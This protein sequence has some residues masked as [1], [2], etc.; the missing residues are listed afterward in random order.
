M[1]PPIGVVSGPLMP[2]RYFLKSTIVSSGS[3]LFVC[4]NAFSP[5]STSCHAIFFLPPYAFSTAA[6]KTRTLARQMSRPVPSPSMKGTIGLSGTWSLLP[7]PIVIGWPFGAADIGEP[8]RK[9]RRRTPYHGSPAAG[10][11]G[12]AKFFHLL[13]LGGAEGPCCRAPCARRGSLRQLPRS[14]RRGRRE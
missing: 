14:Q 8:P 3:Q 4:L 10:T 6:S 9:K 7:G 1:P 11:Y 12:A 5:A 13:R 2:T